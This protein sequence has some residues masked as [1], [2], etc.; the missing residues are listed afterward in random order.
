MAGK[1]VCILLQQWRANKGNNSLDEVKLSR[2][3]NMEQFDLQWI[4]IIEQVFANSSWRSVHS[5]PVLKVGIGDGPLSRLFKTRE[6]Q[7]CTTLT[8]AW[9]KGRLDC[10]VTRIRPQRSQLVWHD[11]DPSLFK[12]RTYCEYSMSKSCNPW[13][14]T[15]R[16]PYKMIYTK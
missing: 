5:S 9:R 16:S 2:K 10:W 11:K 14:A 8:L 3:S 13:T 6:L 12:G 4:R 7:I 1:H 15:V